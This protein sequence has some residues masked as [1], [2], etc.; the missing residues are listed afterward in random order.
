MLVRV[1]GPLVFGIALLFAGSAQAQAP[2]TVPPE[3]VKQLF[4]LLDDPSVK[5]WMAEQRNQDAGSTAAPAAAGASPAGASSDAAVAPS[6]MNT[7]ASST[8][9]RIKHHIE[10]IVRTLPLLPDQF[11]RARAE[12]MQDMSRKGPPGVFLLI[13][14]F[15][16]AGVALAWAT[17]RLTRPFRLWIIA[18]PKDTPIGRAKKIGGRTLYS[19]LLIVSFALGSAGA[20]MLFDWPMLIREIVLTFLLA[21]VGTAAVRMYLAAMLVPSFMNVENAV[22]VRALPVTNETADHWFY[23]LPRIVGVFAFFAAAFILLPGLGIDQDGMLVLSTGA[24]FVLLLLLLVAVWRRPRTQRDG[25]H[26]SSHT[27]T[28]WLLTAY[29]VVLFLQR[30]AGLNIL[31]WFTFAAFFLPLAIVLTQRGVNFVLRPGS[32]DAGRPTIPAVTIAVIDRGVRMI[33]ILAAAYFLARVWGLNMQS[34]RDSDTTTNLILRGL[35][36]VMVI[37]L[38]ADFGWSIIKALIE[39]K[40]GIETPHAVIDDEEVPTLDP[41]Q[42]RLRTLLPI[43][44]NILLAVIVVM[45]VLMMLAS[46][47]IEIGPLIA[48]AG[49][50]G[51]AVGFGAQT[52]VKDVI[53]GVFFLLDDAFRVGEYITSGRYV[54]TVESFSLRSVKLRHHRGPLFTIPFGELGAVQNQSRDWVTDK[55]NITV[56]YNTDIDFARKL[57]KRIGLEL[58]EDP[59]FKHWVLSP[60]KMQGVQEFGEYGIVLRVKVTTRPGGAFSMKRKFYVRLRQVFKE[61]GIELPFPTVH[62]EGLQNSHGAENAPV[63]AKPELKMAVAQSHT[64][65]RRKK[66]STTE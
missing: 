12:T 8:L 25:A 15:I 16:A 53:S 64:N 37:A 49:V 65:R 13:A 34:M 38:A 39:R 2:A 14:M 23:W 50:V 42:A 3:K 56:G 46:M 18:Q 43:I 59:E 51:V 36:N 63:E 60:I 9:D 40:L 31:F 26:Q 20:F 62:V 6:Q 45:A 10:R 1:A 30:I 22:E 7:M 47:G 48:G 21:A 28:T 66:A 4:E 19:S 11:E 17:Y 41:Q 27:A 24:D 35:I 58:A 33:L 32:D 52:I 29:F 5:A 54:G 57:I 44:Q 61:Q 55:F